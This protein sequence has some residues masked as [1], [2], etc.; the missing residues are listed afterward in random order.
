M[1][2]IFLF[3]NTKK[4]FF[5]ILTPDCCSKNLAIARK[6]IICLT[7]G[8]QPHSSLEKKTPSIYDLFGLWNCG[9]TFTSF[10]ECC[11]AGNGETERV[12]YGDIFNVYDTTLPAKLLS[13]IPTMTDPSKTVY[14]STGH[15]INNSLRG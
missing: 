5:F 4:I 9:K 1:N 12:K 6:E 2:S 13:M 15:I 8:L 10:A 14:I 11:I 7:Q 3:K